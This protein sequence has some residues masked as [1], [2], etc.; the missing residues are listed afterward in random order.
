M[1]RYWVIKFS[2]SAP[3]PYMARADSRFAPSQWETS[4]QSNAV[5]HWLGANLESALYGC[6]MIWACNVIVWRW[7]LKSKELLKFQCCMKI[8][9]FNAWVR[10]FVWNFKGSL[11]NSTQNIFSTHWKMCILSINEMLRALGFK[12]SEAFLTLRC[13]PWGVNSLNTFKKYVR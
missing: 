13:K 8:V 1:I 12:S 3:L 4:L 9:S 5:S 11:W 7:A 6:A 10:Y 2:L